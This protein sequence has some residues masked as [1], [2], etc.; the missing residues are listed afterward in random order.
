MSKTV[1]IPTVGIGSR[2]EELTK[3]YNKSLLPFKSKPILSHIIDQ[4]DDNTRFII[5]VGYLSQYVIDFCRLVYPGKIIEFV[6]VDDYTSAMSGTAYTLKKCRNYINSDFWYVPCDAIFNEPLNAD[7]DCFFVKSVVAEMSYHY[8]VFKIENDRIISKS[9]K[10]KKTDDGWYAFT[11]I[12][13]IK[14]YNSFFQGLDD[15][16]SVEF[17]DLIP[18][19]SSIKLLDSWIDLGNLNMYKHQVLN[20]QK[21]DFTKTDEYTYIIDDKVVKWNKDK[22]LIQKKLDRA[23]LLAVFPVCYQRGNFIYYNK[24]EGEVFYKKYNPYRFTKMLKWLNENLWIRQDKDISQNVEDFYIRKTFSRL[25]LIDTKYPWLDNIKFVNGRYVQNLNYYLDKI[26]WQDLISNSVSTYFHGDLQFDNILID[27]EDNFYLIDWRPDFSNNIE[28]GDI[29]YDLSK[30]YGGFL[31]NYLEIKENN[32]SF[33]KTDDAV[34]FSIPKIQDFELYEQLLFY[35][36]RSNNLSKEKVKNLVALIYLNMSPLH[37]SP[38]DLLLYYLGLELL[39][40]IYD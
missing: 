27:H 17:V 38:F 8:T 34:E 14:D 25:D 24:I 1:I 11:G 6:E 10:E 35:F 20:Y 7:D 37:S 30:M 23:S 39:S 13:H 16:K 18:I 32:F 28:C 21:F 2:M 19:G 4:F 26:N 9:F 31:I 40:K 36:I 5:P 12:M 15:L 3:D 29:Y 33:T 22:N